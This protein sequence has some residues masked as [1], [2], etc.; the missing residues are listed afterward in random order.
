MTSFQLFWNVV[1]TGNAMRR[2]EA[3]T[4]AVDRALRRST[5][6]PIN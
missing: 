4:V 3:G 5:G 6:F 1:P 2:Q